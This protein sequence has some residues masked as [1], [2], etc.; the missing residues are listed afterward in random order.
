MKEQCTCL[1]CMIAERQHVVKY[2]V[3]YNCA[4]R[5]FAACINKHNDTQRITRRNETSVETLGV[6]PECVIILMELSESTG[7]RA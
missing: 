3:S 2:S 7:A 1:G 5:M 6:P 4:G